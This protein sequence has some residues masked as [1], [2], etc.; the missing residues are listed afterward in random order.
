MVLEIVMSSRHEAVNAENI[1]SSSDCGNNRKTEIAY[2]LANLGCVDLNVY[3]L[4]N[5]V[6]GW[7]DC[8]VMFGFH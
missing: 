6:Y 2:V 3:I 4:V 8:I 7:Q 1:W 5:K